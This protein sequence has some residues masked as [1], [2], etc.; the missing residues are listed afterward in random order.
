MPKRL[1]VVA[2]IILVLLGAALIVVI[3]KA[4]G[5]SPQPAD[6]MTYAEFTS[7]ILTALGVM[8][9]ALT[10][11][12]GAVALIGWTSFEGLVE[13][14]TS[15][16]LEK[17]FGTQD[18]PTIDTNQVRETVKQELAL[19]ATGGSQEPENESPFDEEQM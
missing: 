15:E 19:T 17:R 1:Q 14:N 10:L 8:L 9:A 18:T 11:F 12:L 7:V 3:Q 2:A 6:E 5:L 13:R 16:Y 4:S